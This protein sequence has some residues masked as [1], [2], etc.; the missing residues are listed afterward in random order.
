MALPGWPNIAPEARWEKGRSTKIVHVAAERPPVDGGW[1]VVGGSG[2]GKQ[3]TVLCCSEED[4]N[5]G[6]SAAELRPHG[7]ASER[8]CAS[9]QRA[10]RDVTADAALVGSIT[11]ALA[12]NQRTVDRLVLLGLGSP[13]SSAAARFQLALALVLNEDL[14]VHGALCWALE[15]PQL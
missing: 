5:A 6:T 13:T 9:L 10:V 1:T 4:S 12:G 3:A 2:R 7:H 11:K 14:C 8:H 15:R